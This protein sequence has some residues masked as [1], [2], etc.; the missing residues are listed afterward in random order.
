MH[1]ATTRR[2]HKDKVYETHLLRRSY[3]ED[4][5]VKNETLANLSALPAATIEL[6]RQSLAGKAH[7]V[8]GE[9]FEIARTSPTAMSRRCARGRQAGDPEVART[10]LSASATW[11]WPRRRPCRQPAS[12]LATT[13]WW[14][15]TTLGADLGSRGLDVDDVYSAMD[16]LVA[17]Q[18]RIERRSP[19]AISRQGRWCST[20]CRPRGWR[21]A[22]ARS[23]R[24]GTHGT[25]RRERPRSS[26]AF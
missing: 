23:R 1:V 9:G 5:K 4:G 7:V 17:R 24:A 18:D 2:Q 12:K 22:A 14:A 11:P 26:T 20:T 10:G 25:A 16:W 21:A 8:A 15:N 3:R 19:G 6:I 13:R